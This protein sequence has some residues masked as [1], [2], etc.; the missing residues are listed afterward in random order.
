MNDK[1]QYILD[2]IDKRLVE[3]KDCYPIKYS[4]AKEKINVKRRVYSKELIKA[5]D[6]RLMKY[7]EM[8]K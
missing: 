2:R 4:H 8:I 6:E 7:E 5:I 1:E 3:L